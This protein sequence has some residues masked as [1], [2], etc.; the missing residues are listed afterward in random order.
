[1]LVIPAPD[2]ETISP[3]PKPANWQAYS[4]ALLLAFVDAVVNPVIPPSSL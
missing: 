2:R 4:A 1:M 3:V